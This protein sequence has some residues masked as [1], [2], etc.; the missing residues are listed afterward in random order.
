MLNLN[1][2]NLNNLNLI[3]LQ[4]SAASQLFLVNPR[5]SRRIVRQFVTPWKLRR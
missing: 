3:Y 5:G 2:L 1:Y 4:I